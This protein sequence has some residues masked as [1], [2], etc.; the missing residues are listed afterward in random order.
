MVF[1]FLSVFAS[2]NVVFIILWQPY[3]CAPLTLIKC[4]ECSVGFE[5]HRINGQDHR[6]F[7][8]VLLERGRVC[9]FSDAAQWD[10]W[11]SF[12]RHAL[13]GGQCSLLLGPDPTV[14]PATGGCLGVQQ[15][16]FSVHSN[17]LLF[18]FCYLSKATVWWPLKQQPL[19]WANG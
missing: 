14:G 5:I 2:V 17:H 19:K 15:V 13:T 8:V 10:S 11:S 4:I 16:N 7:L 12:P 1:V 3:S 9:H 6:H 18:C